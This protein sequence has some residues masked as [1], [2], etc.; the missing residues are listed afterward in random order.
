MSDEQLVAVFLDD[1][2]EPL[3]SSGVGSASGGGGRVRLAVGSLVALIT[4]SMPPGTR[5]NSIRQPF[6]PTVKRWG[7]SRGPKT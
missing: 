3:A 5:M 4:F 7:M 1:R 6:S 2:L